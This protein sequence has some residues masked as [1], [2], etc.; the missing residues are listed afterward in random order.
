MDPVI[1]WRLITLVNSALFGSGRNETQNLA[2]TLVCLGMN[3]LMDLVHSLE[4][5][6][7]F[8]KC[9]ASDR[10]EFSKHSLAVA[11][12]SRSLASKV[13]SDFDGIDASFLSG[14]MCDVGIMTL[15]NI[16]PR[17]YSGFFTLKDLSS[18][19]KPL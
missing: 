9:K 3:Q 6:K 15:D 16:I 2:D 1:S 17:D 18:T 4:L 19:K 7:A 10:V 12:I 8:K 11:F 13:L 5:P 14:L